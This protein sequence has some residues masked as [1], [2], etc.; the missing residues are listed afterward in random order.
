MFAFE[1]ES[2]QR[3]RQI[4]V[5]INQLLAELRTIETNVEQKPFHLTIQTDLT[6]LSEDEIPTCPYVS[7]KRKSM[8][9]H[10]TTNQEH[11]RKSK[12]ILQNKLVFGASACATSTP[13]A[14]AQSKR[15]PQTSTP[16]HSIQE[17]HNPSI[18]LKRLLYHQENDQRAQKRRL[19]SIHN[20]KRSLLPRLQRIEENPQWI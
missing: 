15:V 10:S 1:N 18:P 8:R 7:L 19:S 17:L 6:R 20:G 3:I 14:S 4:K 5:H 16:R 11:R 2:R 9:L 13:K 12:K